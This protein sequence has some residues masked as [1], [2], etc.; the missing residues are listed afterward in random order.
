MSSSFRSVRLRFFDNFFDTLSS[1]SS[2]FSR[3]SFSMFSASEH[4]GNEAGSFL[5]DSLW[6]SSG[7]P[8]SSRKLDLSALLAWSLL[9][10]AASSQLRFVFRRGGRLLLGEILGQVDSPRVSNCPDDLGHRHQ[11][12]FDIPI[13]FPTLP[14]PDVGSCL[15]QLPPGGRGALALGITSPARAPMWAISYRLL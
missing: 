6:P 7:Y 10:S 2:A 13:F 15:F 1:V 3:V 9:L 5:L 4:P 14:F 8:S 12:S 11:L